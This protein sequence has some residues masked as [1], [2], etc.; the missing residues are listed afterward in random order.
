MY[1][2]YFDLCNYQKRVYQYPDAIGSCRYILNMSERD[3]PNELVI[4][5]DNVDMSGNAFDVGDSETDCFFSDFQIPKPAKEKLEKEY[6]C[7][8]A[9]L[10]QKYV[11]KFQKNV[12]ETVNVLCHCHPNRFWKVLQRQGVDLSKIDT[13]TIWAGEPGADG[14]GLYPE[15]LL[16]A[17]AN[18]ENSNL[19]LRKPPNC[20]FTGSADAI[21]KNT[22]RALGQISA[23]GILFINHGPEC[24]HNSLINKL[25]GIKF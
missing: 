7:N 18:L 19:L 25:F 11:N 14:G 21:L 1:P 2:M 3:A 22:Y 23:F 5:D 9:S 20:F 24:L 10:V 16:Y 4:S 17:I 15:F 8:F 12:G 13:K 6:N